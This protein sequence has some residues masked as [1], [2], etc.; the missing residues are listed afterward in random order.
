[1]ESPLVL[2]KLTAQVDCFPE[3]HTKALQSLFKN[4][5]CYT[6]LYT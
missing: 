1:V 3:P 5:T 2:V 6:S 4:Y